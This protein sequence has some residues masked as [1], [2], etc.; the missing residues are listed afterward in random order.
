MAASE[1]VVVIH[2]RLTG[3]P[4]TIPHTNLDPV[5]FSSTKHSHGHVHVTLMFNPCAET[6]KMAIHLCQSK[7]AS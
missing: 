7:D 2:Y 6:S 4:A 3:R 1:W 5:A